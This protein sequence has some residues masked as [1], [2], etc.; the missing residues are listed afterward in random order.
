MSHSAGIKK[1]KKKKKKV[2]R[3]RCISPRI[4]KAEED[5]GLGGAAM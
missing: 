2:S 1:K 5:G 4:R 3:T